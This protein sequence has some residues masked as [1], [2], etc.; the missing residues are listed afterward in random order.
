[1]VKPA[2]YVI[3]ATMV[4]VALGLLLLPLLRRGRETGRSRGIFALALSIALLLPLAAGGLYLWIGTPVALNGVPKAAPPMDVN[5]ALAQLRAHLEQQPDDLQ[6]WLLLAQTDASLARPQQARDAY[7][8]VLRIDPNNT[9]A[10][11][12]WAEADSLLATDHRIAGRALKLL[13]RAALLQPDNQRG[14]W[15]L[16]IA[17]FQHDQFGYAA[18]TW[19]RLLPLLQPG[20]KVAQAVAE[21]IA[22][23]DARAGGSAPTGDTGPSASGPRLQVKVSLAP[24]LKDKLRPGDTLFVYARAP[25]GPPMPLAVARLDASQ[26]PTTVTLTDAMAMTPSRKLSSVPQVVVGARIS[27][28]GQATAHSGDLEGSAG[29]VRVD[30]RQPVTLRIESEHP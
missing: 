18:A 14:L 26:L 15:L 20:S 22:A 21:Q 2:F 9:A 10:M 27:H 13:E 3:A 11:V 1:M 17:Q 23:A 25:S 4:V 5:Q 12:G 30:R 19:R 7:D 8:Q 29:T 24:S 28:S 6:G 16:G